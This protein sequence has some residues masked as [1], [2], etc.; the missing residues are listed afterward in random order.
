MEEKRYHE[1]V[2]LRETLDV[3]SVRPGDICMD[4]TLG[5][6]GHAEAILR[7]LGGSGMLIG[8]DRDEEA[9]FEARE[10]L[11]CFGK[12][13]ALVRENF[14]NMDKVLKDM[15]IKG[16][17]VLLFDLGLS[18]RQV[19]SPERGF[20]FQAEGPLDMR[21]DSR[22]KETAWSLLERLPVKELSRI[23]REY[24]EEPKAG[25]IARKIGYLR[26]RGMLPR[27]TI[28]LKKMIESVAGSGSSRRKIHPATRTF[29]AFRIAVN[30]ELE[31]LEEALEKALGIMAPGGRIGVISYHSL[32]DRIVKQ[33]FRQKAKGC[34]CPPSAPECRC[35]KKPELK[36][37]TKKPIRPSAEEIER[38]P[39]SRSARLRA[40]EVLEE[41]A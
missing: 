41:S 29:M 25:K 5:G 23:I 2:L 22:Q 26:E 20:S 10:R 15:D 36:I 7:K 6:G 30:N 32:E 18:S 21:M 19:D 14:V 37:L 16:V 38:N 13:A 8:L 1:P 3:L 33:F 27:T 12:R 4:L 24:G 28:G 11:S 40:A 31:N 39:R 35:G 9:L 17:N 34:I